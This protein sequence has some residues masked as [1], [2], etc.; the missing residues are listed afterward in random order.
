MLLKAYDVFDC[1]TMPASSYRVGVQTT[2]TD[3]Q[4]IR[5]DRKEGDKEKLVATRILSRP[6]K[7]VTT[8]IEEFERYLYNLQRG[9]RVLW[10]RPIKALGRETA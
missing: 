8:V 1:T 7:H 4:I 10:D 3:A 2:E 6:K 5:W 9:P